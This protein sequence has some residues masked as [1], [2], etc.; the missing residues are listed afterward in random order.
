MNYGLGI[1]LDFAY[2]HF[3]KDIHGLYRFDGSAQYE[4]ASPSKSR[5]PSLG[6]CTF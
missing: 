1:I 2:S 6:Y 4:Y 3:C 5:K